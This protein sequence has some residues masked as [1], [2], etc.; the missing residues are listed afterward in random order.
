M[1][2]QVGWSQP[3]GGVVDIPVSTDPAPEFVPGQHA[4]T[5]TALFRVR[6]PDSPT[7]HL[8]DRE[9]LRAVVAPFCWWCRAT[10]DDGPCPGRP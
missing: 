3:G 4:W 9:N 7:G 6:S 8:L 1:T 2:V 10:A 5:I